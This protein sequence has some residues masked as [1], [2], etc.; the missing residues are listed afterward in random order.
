MSIENEIERLG[1]LIPVGS[2][3]F[4]PP[5]RAYVDQLLADLGITDPPD[6]YIRFITRY[7]SCAPA[8]EI[9]ISL[10][11]PLPEYLHARE[12]GLSNPEH[13][14]I[15][16]AHFY[17]SEQ[18]TKTL[19]LQWAIRTYRD[20][21][22]KGFFPVADDGAGNQICW[23]PG[24]DGTPV[25]HWWDHENEWDI[26]DYEED[27]GEAMPPEAKYQNLYFISTSLEGMMQMMEASS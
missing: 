26:D 17:G 16:L 25:F 8:K 15:H 27:T 3:A 1:G 18:A 7:G 19:S 4:A 12:T 11:N 24:I 23:G 10:T 2:D 20:R 13:A 21:L 6:D 5:T 22:P 14:R 9:Q